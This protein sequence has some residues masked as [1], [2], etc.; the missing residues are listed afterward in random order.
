MKVGYPD[1]P[2]D[3]VLVKALEQ[4]RRIVMSKG[5]SGRVRLFAVYLPPERKAQPDTGLVLYEA[6]NGTLGQMEAREFRMYLESEG[7][8]RLD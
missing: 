5:L 3:T 4:C 2:D 7:V 1:V 6:E 8:V